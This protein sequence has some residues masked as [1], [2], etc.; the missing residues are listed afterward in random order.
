[1]KNRFRAG[2]IA[3]ASLALVATPAL[4]QSFRGDRTAG[5]PAVVLADHVTATVADD[6][7]MDELVSAN[8]GTEI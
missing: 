7:T 4:C 2:G 5:V 8:S 3:A 1:M 6:H